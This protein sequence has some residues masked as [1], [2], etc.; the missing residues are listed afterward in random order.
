[1]RDRFF[2]GCAAVIGLWAVLAFI[3]IGMFHPWYD[4][5]ITLLQL[6]GN[7]NDQV[8]GGL[9]AGEELK[10]LLDGRAS[11]VEIPAMLAA[12]DVHPPVYYWVAEIW[13]RI[14]GGDI[15]AVRSLSLVSV[16]IALLL[17]SRIC[18]DLSGCARFIMVSAGVL[19]P[20]MNF[21]AMNARGYGVAVLF[22]VACL[23]CVHRVIDRIRD[24]SPSAAGRRYFFASIFGG[25]A[26]LT[27][28][29]T[30]LVCAPA[31]LSMLPAVWR[32]DRHAAIRS[33]VSGAALFVVALPFLRLQLF[34][35]PG[36]Y[37]GFTDPAVEFGLVL[38][39]MGRQVTSAAGFEGLAAL[40]MCLGLLVACLS[41]VA[42]AAR[43]IR[44]AHAR[45]HA[46]V[47]AFFA[48]SIFCLFA[49]TDKTITTASPR[50][51]ILSLPS[52]LIALGFLIDGVR[53]WF[54]GATAL[55]IAAT[56]TSL[57]LVTI[58]PP[59]S[60]SWSAPLPF[61]SHNQKRE[62]RDVL[63]GMRPG[64]DFVIFPSSMWS[65]AH[66]FPLLND[67]T[68]SFVG[69]EEADLTKAFEAAAQYERVYIFPPE[70]WKKTTGR[71]V[72][73]LIEGLEACGFVEVESRLWSRTGPSVETCST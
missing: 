8:Q 20:A 49:A 11:M 50:Y 45:V 42:V 23:F 14:F 21:A 63:R 38:F 24:G 18:S 15:Q 67:G 39:N 28:Y 51:M 4:E 59:A 10:A 2:W 29:F 46:V 37:D 6:A 47:L 22:T 73:D 33:L 62:V 34:A 72:D 27:H 58:V 41:C 31:V 9:Q 48:I 57:A 40:P 19:L 69:W 3:A 64:R 71:I 32:A 1:M 35:R 43:S 12:Y 65:S 13:T 36:Q 16:A 52:L 66:S 44:C 55:A 56:V 68:P 26:F 60:G 7:V 5:G 70:S 54:S 61:A 17:L 30:I 25:L 53:R